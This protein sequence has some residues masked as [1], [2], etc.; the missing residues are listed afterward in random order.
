MKNKK[1]LLIVSA[2]AAV[3]PLLCAFESAPTRIGI[4]SISSQYSGHEEIT[5]QALNNT[6]K[7]MSDFDRSG[8][9]KTPELLVDLD[10]KPKGLY[11]VESKNMVIHGN[12]ASDFPA[13]T[14]VMDLGKFWNLSHFSEFESATNQVF[15]FLRNYKDSVTIASARA[16]CLQARENIKKATAA[17]IDLWNAGDRRRALFLFG[18]V[19]HTIQDSFAPAHA[20]RSGAQSNYNLKEVCFYGVEMGKKINDPSGRAQ[21]T[22]YHNSPDSSDAIWNMSPAQQQQALQEWPNEKS[23]QCD[24]SGSYPQTEEQ[25]QAC[26]KHEARLARVA[27]EKYLFL[28]FAHLN[29]ASPKPIADF[30]ASLDSRLF[31]GPVGD[32]QLDQKMANGIMR[33]E[34][35]SNQE[36]FGSEPQSP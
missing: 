10:P 9:F 32:G 6:I 8:I 14:T 11:G 25:K 24:K 35:L 1:T 29:S 30:L 12:F 22:C 20:R 17:A 18:H 21:P 27:T 28:V 23:I 13:Q 26:M 4:L 5:R 15:H 19:T 34:N 33:C 16:T 2:V 36:I 7:R 31:D 3:I